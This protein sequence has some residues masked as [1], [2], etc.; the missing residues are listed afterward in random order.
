MFDRSYPN[1]KL[2]VADII[3]ITDL[4]VNVKLTLEGSTDVTSYVH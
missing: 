2:D 4:E 3:E 1:E